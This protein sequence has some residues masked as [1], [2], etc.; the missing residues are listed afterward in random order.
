MIPTPLPC[1]CG[2]A[3]LRLVLLGQLLV[4]D[5]G[6]LWRRTGGRAGL[7]GLGD[8]LGGRGRRALQ[9]GSSHGAGA[10]LGA[11]A[12]AGLALGRRRRR[13][14]RLGEW[15]AK[16]LAQLDGLGVLGI[17]RDGLLEVFGARGVGGLAQERA[18]HPQRSEIVGGDGQRA[19]RLFESLLVLALLSVDLRQKDSGVGGF[20]VSLDALLADDH[21]L[22]EAA[23]GQVSLGQGLVGLRG[24]VRREGVLELG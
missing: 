13:L 2:R 11:G 3:V 20:G 21:R 16:L 4:G 10:A 5:L 14:G 9:P 1:A 8:A 12:D 7:P 17:R 19:L 15:D 18:T 6:L 24:G 22:H 23:H